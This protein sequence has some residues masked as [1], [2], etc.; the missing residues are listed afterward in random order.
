MDDN[1]APKKNSEKKARVFD[2]QAMFA[3]TISNAPRTEEPTH[4][5]Q[6]VSVSSK[7]ESGV[8]SSAVS[9]DEDGKPNIMF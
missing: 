4:V 5:P 1:T 8:S 7:S 6:S 3:Q 9:D 2:L